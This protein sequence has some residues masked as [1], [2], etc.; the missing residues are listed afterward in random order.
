MTNWWAPAL[1]GRILAALSSTGR[2]SRLIIEAD[3][4][5]WACFR[6]G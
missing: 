6:R 5:A 1:I 2:S 3:A 4:A